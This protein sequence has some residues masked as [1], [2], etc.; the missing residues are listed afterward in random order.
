MWENKMR[1]TYDGP[2]VF[3]RTETVT[4]ALYSA[5]SEAGDLYFS[6]A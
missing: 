6:N 1:N 5:T 3:D 4:V 2:D